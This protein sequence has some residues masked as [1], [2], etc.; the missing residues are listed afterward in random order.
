M[1]CNSTIRKLI[2]EGR[3][4]EI[5]SVI[6]NSA[7]EG[8]IDFTESL[9]RLVDEDL[10]SVKTAYAAAPNPDELKMR[11]KGISVTGGGI[12]G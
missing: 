5:G 9:R 12:I 4:T 3:D 8:M 10:I 11:L 2:A 1:I 7:H 6:R